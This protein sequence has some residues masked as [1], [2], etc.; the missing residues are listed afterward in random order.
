M[1]HVGMGYGAEHAASTWQMLAHDFI[2]ISLGH[3]F[4]CFNFMNKM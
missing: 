2:I 3:F 4:S 1:T